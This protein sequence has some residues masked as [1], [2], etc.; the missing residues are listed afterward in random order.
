MKLVWKRKFLIV[1][2]ELVENS[3]FEDVRFWGILINRKCVLRRQN[4][5]KT[6]DKVKK[7]TK[8]TK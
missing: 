5:N 8:F 2:K 1:E 3:S 7:L 4:S 6:I